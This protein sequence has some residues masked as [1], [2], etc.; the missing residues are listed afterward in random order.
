MKLPRKICFFTGTLSVLAGAERV[1]AVLASALAALGHEVHIVCQYGTRSVFA[2][3]P[4]VRLHALYAQRPSFKTHYLPAVRQLR[5]YLK[6]H[7]I[8]TLIDVDSNL[9]WF[10][11][12][13][14]VGLGLQHIAWEH[15]HYSQDLGLPARRI[16]RHLAARWCDTI[17]VLTERDRQAWLHA[18]PHLG[19]SGKGPNNVSR[20]VAIANP[21][22]LPWPETL[23]TN[24]P[25][26]VLAVGRLEHVK[27][28][29]LLLAAW[30][31]LHPSA[32]EWQLHIVG[33]GSQRPALE[34]QRAALGLQNVVEILPATPDI[35]AHY[36][37]AS[38][39]A[40]SSRF[41]GFG[42]VLIEAMAWGL[43]IAAFDCETGPRELI[44][45]E[46]T[47]L[48][49]Q[50]ENPQALSESLLRLMHNPQLRDQMAAHAREQSHRYDIRAIAGQWQ[51]LMGIDAPS[52]SHPT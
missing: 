22:P 2:L 14:R 27:G 34:A 5:A 30:A 25:Q 1:T 33:N 24:R 42:L 39:L 35:A 26:R 3:H 11:L 21:L 7:R 36:A 38:I 9:A 47:G 16:A 20:I 37:E 13:A 50:A 52:L 44:A 10:S 8:Q 17:V 6:A 29:D 19:Q 40:L 48:L 49:A 46:H 12:P 4:G 15:T 23:P 18:L 51:D 28:F 32:P 45:H 31:L 43:A 41:E